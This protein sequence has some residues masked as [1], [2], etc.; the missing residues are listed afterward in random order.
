MSLYSR[1]SARR[2]LLDTVKFRIVSQVATVSG[3]IVLIRGISAEDF[4]VLSL[5]YAF[6]PVVGTL[7]SLGL[8]HVLRRYQPEYLRAGNAAAAAWLVRIVAYCRFITNIIILG[9]ILLT[10]DYIAP[11]F[12]LTPHKL[13]FIGFSVL[14][15]LHFQTAIMQLALGS[16]MLHRYGI[17]ATA[18]LAIIKLLLYSAFSYA[19]ELSLET[20]IVTDTVAYAAA[21]LLMRIAYRRHCVPPATEG[22]YR[23]DRAERTR[24]I[25]YGLLNNFDDVGVL[26]MYSTLD[27]FFLA[28]FLSTTAVG[29]YSFYSRL[30]HMVNNLLPAHLFG[31]VVQPLLFSVPPAEA[32]RRMPIYFSFLVNMGLLLQWPTLVLAIAY[33]AELVEVVFGGKFGEYSWLLPAMMSFGFLHTISEPVYLVAQYHERAGIILISKFFAVFNVLGMLVLVPLWGVYGAALSAGTS[34]VVKNLFIWWYVRDTAVW[35]NARTAL[36]IGFSLWGATAVA[37]LALKQLLD[38]PALAHLVVGT[39]VIG[40][41]SLLHV[42]TKAIA[43]SDREILSSVSPE[44]TTPLLQRLGL[45]PARL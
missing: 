37:C 11:V 31:N 35:I 23:P 7:A 27:S 22:G 9:A 6:I 12:D 32:R 29:I 10:W 14:I 40:A 41:A 39:C 16:H 38:A 28:A 19:D 18:V 34:Q 45:L 5:L 15:F 13:A 24:L 26:L 33:H 4:G 25:R 1:G 44:R 30:R 20:A 3:Y 21:Y 17:G 43:Q 2:S 8:T 36:A 42:R